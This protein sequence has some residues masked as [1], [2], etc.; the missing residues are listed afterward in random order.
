LVK[1]STTIGPLVV[2]TRGPFVPE[3]RT[4]SYESSD[5]EGADIDDESSGV[6]S[7]DALS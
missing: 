5:K 1:I 6:G 4:K 2:V 3:V 7:F